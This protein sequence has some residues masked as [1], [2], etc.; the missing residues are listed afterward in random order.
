MK[1]L[2]MDTGTR[3]SIFT[4]LIVVIS[5]LLGGCAGFSPHHQEPP[6]NSKKE[7]PEE[8]SARDESLKDT[9]VTENNREYKL[10]STPFGVVKQSVD[11][12][13]KPVR[14]NRKK[15]RRQVAR[16][17]DLEPTVKSVP[18]TNSHRKSPVRYHKKS[19]T[20]PSPNVT[21][22]VV[23]NFDD[24]DLYEV[25][26][27]FAELLGINYIADTGVRGKVTIHTAGE[28]KSSELFS[29]FYQI[30]EVNGFTAIKEGSLYKIV[31][32]K[33]AGRSSILSGMGRDSDEV[34]PSQRVVIQII[35]LEYIAA[36][37]MIKLLTPF[38]S[39][40]GSIVSHEQT[41]TLV[42]VD[43][44]V[45]VLKA[46]KLIET[47]DIDMFEA[48]DH[49]F[50]L[51]ENSSTDDMAKLLNDIL[52]AYGSSLKGEYK[53]VPI[54][55][56]N[57][58][59]VISR[60]PKVFEKIDK[61][62]TRLDAVSESAEPQIYVYFMKN[63]M[64]SDLG[65]LLTG[66]FSKSG[67]AKDQRAKGPSKEKEERSPYAPPDIFARKDKKKQKTRA[68][69]PGDFEGSGMLRGEV[70]ITADEIR[71]ALIIEATPSDYQIIH[72]IL[73]R[74]DVMP[75]QVLIEVTFADITL[76]ESTDLGVEW[77]FL[78]DRDSDTG[79]LNANISSSGLSYTIGLTQEWM[80]ALSALAQDKKVNILSSPSVLASDNKEA[81]INI[82]S[83][84]PVASAQYNF[85]TGGDG[86]VQTNIQYRDTGVI[87]SVTPHINENG[88]VSMEVRQEVSEQSDGVNVGGEE[89]P[90]F[91]ERSVNTTLTVKHGQTIVMGGLISETINR[92]NSGVPVL[93]SLPLVGYLFG[94]RSKSFN[95]TELIIMI[96]P[97]VI[98]SLDDVD[99]VT[100]E[101][102]S[103]VAN[104]LGGLGYEAYKKRF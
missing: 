94:S 4:V 76:D 9:I 81:N 21:G 55:H 10:H 59:L 51:L 62:I 33:E 80:H 61:F 34:A 2:M 101:F 96:T 15:T 92:G 29:V 91:L 41:N 32:L 79:L 64:A 83:Q 27:T 68:T 72:D 16:A 99:A 31:K 90:S 87:L 52:T 18:A 43:K 73:E 103:K 74:L 14:E 57:T 25:I 6:L 35:P 24:A 67:A 42:L 23:L 7:S 1:Q 102:K 69:A 97:Y 78:K 56:L 39:A 53:L 60:N 70:K 38:I 3:S 44:G 58:I 63:S 85:E 48:A 40:E 28:I 47:F 46:L 71:N 49:R 54:N 17:A 36:A 37:E 8:F 75:R 104:A 89:F 13:E 30:L 5:L 45:N 77:D 22:P 100:F 19:D 26:R 20:E 84:I 66:I 98:V 11:L 88:L 65:G 95:K 50:Y 12:T 86:V 93:R 82:A